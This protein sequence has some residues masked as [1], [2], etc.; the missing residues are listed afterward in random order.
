MFTDNFESQTIYMKINT[1][2]IVRYKQKL[3]LIII[4]ALCA[5]PS[6]GLTAVDATAAY[7]TNNVFAQIL[8]G[9]KP[10]EIVYE[11]EYALAFL[12]IRPRARVHV[13]VIPKGPYA[14]VTRFI[15]EASSEEQLGLLQ[16]IRETAR[17][18]K[19]DQSG[20]R[21]ITN[22]GKDGGQTVPHLHFHIM[23]GEAVK[24]TIE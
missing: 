7:D 6:F 17:I 8:R 23:G 12:D 4:L 15:E 19:V 3:M 1:Y 2:I 11:N 20:F 10:A 9:E 14:N 24:L 13:L 5:F 16:A 22:T 18:L 21:L